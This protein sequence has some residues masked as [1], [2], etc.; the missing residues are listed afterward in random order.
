MPLIK[1]I[2]LKLFVESEVTSSPYL[3][4]EE[5]L[6]VDLQGLA[7]IYA[8]WEEVTS[9][10]PSKMMGNRVTQQQLCFISD[11]HG[12]EVQ[13]TLSM[14]SPVPGRWVRD[15]NQPL[16]SLFPDYGGAFIWNEEGACDDIDDELNPNL[17]GLRADFVKTQ[18]EFERRIDSYEPAPFEWNV[19]HSKSLTQAAALLLQTGGFILYEHAYE[20]QKNKN[21]RVMSFEAENLIN[22]PAAFEFAKAVLNRETSKALQDLQNPQ[23]LDQAS[24]LEGGITAVNMSIHTYEVEVL[25][26]I[27][28]QKPEWSQLRDGWGCSPIEAA[29][30]SEYAEAVTVLLKHSPGIDLLEPDEQGLSPLQKAFA[31]Y[32]ERSDE[33]WG[34]QQKPH[35]SW[36]VLDQL[37]EHLKQQDRVG[38]LSISRELLMV[39]SH[40][41]DT[42][43]AWIEKQVLQ[44]FTAF[45]ED[46]TFKKQARSL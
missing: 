29:I 23:T 12:R 9:K 28:R 13:T 7:R 8:K 37:F 42:L 22:R 25:E 21:A 5:D 46:A 32:K 36:A 38:E 18:L 20:E 24:F 17:K 6:N 39:P 11:D 10:I 2:Q 34:W 45:Q 3:V 27:L 40:Y 35:D 31:Q 1:K 43:K 26:E 44:D 30:F 4:R 33:P 19:Y 15:T 41:R 14:S 16:W